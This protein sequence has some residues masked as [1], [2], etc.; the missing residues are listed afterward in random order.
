[1]KKITSEQLMRGIVAHRFK[2]EKIFL[3]GMILAMICLPFV[4]INYD[5]T[6]YLPDTAPS[7]EGLNLLAQEF[8]HPG[9]ARVMI[10]D[11]TL[12]EAKS[13]KDRIQEVEGVGMV[14]W[15]D[16]MQQI[17]QPT[18]F[19][20]DDLVGMYYKDGYAIMDILFE[21]GDASSKTREALKTIQDITGDKG[22][23][24]GTAVD[25]LTIHEALIS[26]VAIAGI[27]VVAIILGILCLTTS[28]WVEPLLFMGVI[29]IGIILNMGS[30]IIYGEISFFTFS[31]AAILQLAI[32]MDYSIFLLHTYTHK[33]KEMDDTKEAMAQALM[34]S[35]TSIVSSGMTTIIGFLAL[36]LMVFAIGKDMGM[37]LAKG[38][39]LS[40]MTV[41]LLMP[42]LIL[43]WEKKIDAYSH[44]VWVKAPK[45]L[46]VI[47][48]KWR[49]GVIVF[50]LLLIFPAYTAQ[51]MNHF[52]YGNDALSASEGTKVYEDTKLINE[53]FGRSNLVLVIVPNESLVKEKH[54][55]KEMEKLEV[56]NYVQSL[57]T[58]LPPGITESFLP[59]MI[60]GQ[61][62]TENYSRI[63][64]SVNTAGESDL[65]FHTVDQLTEITKRFYPEGSYITGLTPATKDMKNIIKSDYERVNVLS[66][67][68]VAMVL[69]VTFRKPLIAFILLVPIQIAI[70][71][72]MAIPYFAGEHI[73]FIGYIIV[74]C[75]QLGA[76]IDYAILLTNTYLTNR[77]TKEKESAYIS[78]INESSLSILTS[79]IILTA[80]GY[81]LYFT[82]SITGVA[83]IGRLIGRGALFSMVLVLSIL[84]TLLLFADRF[85]IKKGVKKHEEI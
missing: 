3:L 62:K 47:L 18:S 36:T 67:I 14:L 49:K 80:V 55:V 16:T 21:E 11:I 78:S 30:N 39:V 52:L 76:T 40:L 23:F 61:F 84:P 6:K 41:M 9:M 51:T 5:M 2:I 25:N 28:S 82:S 59:S 73:I 31:V 85:I 56:T 38:I 8:G 70:Y 72:N 34:A 65:A 50:A 35:A 53:K 44:P 42:A 19:F 33:K 37:V 66:L 29:G 24:T 7:K 75:L 71:M 26:E 69:L 15:L 4:T 22:Y 27:L 45:R 48:Y 57:A 13:I 77:K 60:T 54:M 81:G 79:G 58:V 74:G 32:A 83:E 43:R 63:L 46:G 12:Y 64:V 68:G 17:Y 1:M 20:N 10:G